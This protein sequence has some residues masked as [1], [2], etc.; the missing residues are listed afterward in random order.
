MATEQVSK[1]PAS[2][3]GKT[4]DG[5]VKDG[6]TKITCT[7]EGSASTWTIKAEGLPDDPK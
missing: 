4:V 5:F 6:A 1:V 7:K 2:R 3:V